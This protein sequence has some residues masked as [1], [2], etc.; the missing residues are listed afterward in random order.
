MFFNMH[1]SSGI[2]YL[3]D[4]IRN[5]KLSISVSKSS[6]A[7][8]EMLQNDRL[9]FLHYPL[10]AYLNINSSRNKVLREILKDVPLDYLV[11]SEIEL[12]ESFPNVQF[13]LNQYEVRA[14][15]DRHKH[16]GGLIEFVRQGFICK[17][18]T[19]YEPNCSE[20]I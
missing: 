13:K 15:R 2:N 17:R 16:G 20:C 4:D 9:K 8:L 6:A 7:D 12:D 18:L 19:K 11:I 5:I 3:D 1:T 10:I 14:R